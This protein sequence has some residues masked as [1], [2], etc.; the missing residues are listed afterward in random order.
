MEGPDIFPDDVVRVIDDMAEVHRVQDDGL[1]WVDDMALVSVYSV[2]FSCNTR[3][4][5]HYIY[6]FVFVLHI[7]V[8]G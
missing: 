1:A 4:S 8:L 6:V 2:V 5:F 3:P 7:I